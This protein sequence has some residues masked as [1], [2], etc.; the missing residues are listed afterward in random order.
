[1]KNLKRIIL[2]MVV[3]AGP[4]SAQSISTDSAFHSI[5]SL[6]ESGLYVNAEVEARRVVEMPGLTDSAVI[7]A[8]KWIAFSLVAQG[9]L[10]LASDHFAALLKLDP[11]YE[12]DPILTSPKILAVFDETKAQLDARRK[13][14][15][16]TLAEPPLRRSLVVS[17]R[18]VVFPG[19]EQLHTKRTTAGYLFLAGGIGTLGAGIAFEVLRSSTRNEYLSATAASTIESKYS[20]YNKY[21]KA[22][23]YAF[24]A[25]AIV[26]IASEVDVFGSA[27]S[28]TLSLGP[29]GMPGSGTSLSLRIKI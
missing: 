11:Q 21:Y 8:E 26:Y 9:K 1:M 7:A 14:E 27:N 16:D 18:T 6:F 13:S 3:A 20:A 24:S 15:P 29:A 23:A 28:A 25:F 4:A 5:E 22:E 19:W 12:L 17:F 2:F 10:S